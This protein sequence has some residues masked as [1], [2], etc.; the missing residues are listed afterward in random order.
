LADL[1]AEV[2]ETPDFD[3][4]GKRADR[5][6]EFGRG[7]GSLAH[8]Q[9]LWILRRMLAGRIGMSHPIAKRISSS[10]F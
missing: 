8:G 2:E 7:D 4:L 3:R 1:T 9:L 10:I 6:R 5:R